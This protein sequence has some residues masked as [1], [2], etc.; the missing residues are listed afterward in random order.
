MTSWLLLPERS[1]WLM[2]LRSSLSPTCKARRNFYSSFH[3]LRLVSIVF[4]SLRHPCAPFI[5]GHPWDFHSRGWKLN[6]MGLVAMATADA[7][8][9]EVTQQLEEIKSQ[10]KESKHQEKEARGR[11]Q[12]ME[13]QL[14]GLGLDP[15]VT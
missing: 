12:V 4:S 8:V 10:L 14:Q 7:C 6:K 11:I 3:L 15:D 13:A 2:C 1:Y 5:F 9:Y